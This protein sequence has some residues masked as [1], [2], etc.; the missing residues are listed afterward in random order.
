MSCTYKKN[1]TERTIVVALNKHHVLIVGRLWTFVKHN[2]VI[3]CLLVSINTFIYM[4]N[5]EQIFISRYAQIVLTSLLIL[6]NLFRMDKKDYN[7]SSSFLPQKMI[8]I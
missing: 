6:F 5:S 8:S 4:Y 7:L 1:V 2:T 3:L